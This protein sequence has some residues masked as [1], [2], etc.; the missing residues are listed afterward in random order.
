MRL[1]A[2]LTAPPHPPRP[3]HNMFEP[4]LCVACHCH[5]LRCAPPP[6]RKTVCKHC[7][8]AAPPAQFSARPDATRHTHAST[9]GRHGAR[10][11]R[12]L[13]VAARAAKSSLSLGKAESDDLDKPGDE[14]VLV[15]R[16]SLAFATADRRCLTLAEGDV[17]VCWPERE[18]PSGWARGRNGGREGVFPLSYVRALRMVPPRSS[19]PSSRRRRRRR[20]R[21][22]GGRPRR[23]GA[24]PTRRSC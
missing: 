24:R 13:D 21:R 5:T 6:L 22:R 10:R 18:A 8:S 19:L 14:L 11:L 3:S 2:P 1:E 15:V 16:S 4:I 9:S 12:R 7:P 17:F 20:P 23:R